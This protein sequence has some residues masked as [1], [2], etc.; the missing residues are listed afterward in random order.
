MR[1]NP[2]LQVTSSDSDGV[3]ALTQADQLQGFLAARPP[4]ESLCRQVS[5]MR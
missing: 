1:M 5:A 4:V 3:R 2:T